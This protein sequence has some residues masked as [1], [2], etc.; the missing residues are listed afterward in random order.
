[1]RFRRILCPGWR[2]LESVEGNKTGNKGDETNKQAFGKT[3][4]S[5]GF[6][7]SIRSDIREMLS[8]REMVKH[9]SDRRKHMSMTVGIKAHNRNTLLPRFRQLSG[10]LQF[11]LLFIH[12]SE[13]K[14]QQKNRKREEPTPSI[15]QRR[16]ITPGTNRHTFNQIDMERRRNGMGVKE[17]NSSAK[18]R[19]VH[20]ERNARQRP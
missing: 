14:T 5:E 9:L 7:I 6:E 4:S 13:K 20:E 8:V 1:M 2:K 17:Q 3:K 12:E 18:P 16:N 19:K 10:H 11:N 15:D